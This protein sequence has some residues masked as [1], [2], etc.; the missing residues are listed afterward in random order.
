MPIAAGATI[1][2]YKVDREIGR[3]GMGVVFLAHDT[4]LGRTV[5]LKALPDDVARDPDR[6]QRFE[7]EARVLASLSHPNIA[8]I[9]GLE[10]SDGHRYLALELIEGETLG[11]RLS[12]GPLP[13]SEALDICIQI[14][15]GM[16]AAHDAGVV[17]RDLKPANLMITAADEVKILDFG[18]AKGRVATDESGLAKSPALIDSPTLSS[19]TLPHSPTFIGPATSPGVI[20]GTAAYLSP[21]QARGKIVDRRTDIW[22]F[23]CVLFECLTGHRLFDGETVSDTIASVL[24]RP[25]DWK[26][27]P[28]HTPSRLRE[29]L[30]RCLERDPKRRLR[31]VGDARLTLEEIKSGRHAA[32]DSA[33]AASPQAAASARRRITVLLTAALL[34][35]AALGAAVWNAL[36]PRPKERVMHLTLQLPRDVRLNRAVLGSET[37]AIV[38]SPVGSGRNEQE[39]GRLYLRRMDEPDFQLVPGTEGTTGLFMSPDGRTIEYWAPAGEQTNDLRRFRMPTDRSAPPVPV[40]NV[41]PNWDTDGVWLESGDLV[42]STNDGLRHVRLPANGSAALAPERFAIPGINGRFYPEGRPLPGDRGVFLRAIWYEGGVYRQGVGV[43]DPK[44]GKAKLLLR[45]GGGATYLAGLLLFTRNDVLFAVP[46]DPGKL[47]VKGA[48]VGIMNGL[49][50]ERTSLNARFGLTRDGTLG[51]KAGGNVMRSRHVVIVDRQGNVTDWSADRRPFE[52]DLKASPDG[53]R[54]MTQINNPNAI[55]ELWVLDRGQSTARRIRTRAGA[56]CLGFCWSP[57][58]RSVAYIQ[59]A[60]DP[61]DGVYVIDV[62]GGAPAR[63]VV[64]RP[65][66]TAFLVPHSWTR[67]GIITATLVDSNRVSLWAFRLPSGEGEPAQP[68]LIYGGEGFNSLGVISPDGRVM[69]FQS[70]ETGLEEEYVVAWSGDAPAGQPIM[71]SR[72]GGTIARWSH[73]GKRLYYSTQGRVMSVDITTSPRLSSS[74]PTQA[75]NL[76]ALRVPASGVG[77]GLYDVL[78]DGRLLAVQGSEEEEE[79]TQINLVLHFDEV[80]KQRMRAAAK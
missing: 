36:H 61:S 8:A 3:G 46:F 55:T 34:V 59:N 45:D 27:L 38:G 47:E 57:D 31:D 53:T 51:Y 5:A 17:H 77:S 68:R 26:T 28:K 54:A 9:F 6:L 71:V 10:E 56:D 42:L 20:L 58:G 52:Y 35:G 50:Q 76:R 13:L 21:E 14:A 80:V 67:D 65:S 7:R 11:E 22:S 74:A 73:D 32:D 60:N 37:M 49:R 69:A 72:G 75:W 16:E 24:E 2:P 78:P 44:S 41:D 70:N 25:I 4:R 12:R 19:P 33:A 23:G 40:G 79:V 15:S 18:L 64:K 66:P 43:L 1:G 39:R 62:D 29:L 63:R 30:E 48:P